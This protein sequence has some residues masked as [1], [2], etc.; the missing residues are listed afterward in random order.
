MAIQIQ[1]RRGTSALWASTNPLLAQGEVG[2]ETD[3]LRLKVGDGITLWNSLAYYSTAGGTTSAPAPS[4]GAYMAMGGVDDI[5]VEAVAMSLGVPVATSGGTGTNPT[6]GN[7]DK[8]FN[9]NTMTVTSNYTFPTGQSA[10]S[11]GP[12]TINSGITVTVPSGSRWVVL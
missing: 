11:V 6:G 7:T 2:I 9:M 3:T 1:L 12:I 10:S 5:D 4:A 8:V